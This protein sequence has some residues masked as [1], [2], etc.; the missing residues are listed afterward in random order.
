MCD[1]GIM[2]RFEIREVYALHNVPSMPQNGF[3]T[4]PGPIMAAVD[5]F[6]INITGRGGHG[7][8]P[9]ETIDPVVAACGMVT[10]I[11]TIVSRNNHTENQLVVS[12]TQIHTGTVNN[13]IPGTAYIN[14]TIR[15]FDPDVKA[16]VE[17]RMREIVAG[18]AASYGV[19]A[20]LIYD[21][22]YPATVN[23]EKQTAFA[24]E[25]ARGL[26]GADAVVDTMTKVA[27]AEDF[28]YMLEERPGSYLFLGAG[29][30]A[31]LHHPKYNFNDEI[32]PVGASF[33]AQLVER[34]QP[35]ARG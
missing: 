20:E 35:V 18:Q 2:D 1:E 10:A 5:S 3:F 32:A 16:M 27:G 21:H 30:G 19:E 11:Q 15:T 14:G 4:T 22:G 23:S 31:G 25:V 24:A 8:M 33:F 9:H 26:V 12:V 28:A 34:A 17:R 29:D 13:V 6:T 7:A